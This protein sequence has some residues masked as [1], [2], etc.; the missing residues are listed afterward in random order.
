MKKRSAKVVRNTAE[1]QISLT[2][3]IDG[4]GK[5]GVIRVGDATDVPFRHSLAGGVPGIVIH[6]DDFHVRQMPD[7]IQA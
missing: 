4:S 1:T 7:G 5:S 2:L 3:T 6:D